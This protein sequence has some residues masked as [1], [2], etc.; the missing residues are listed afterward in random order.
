MSKKRL[1]SWLIKRK[2]DVWIISLLVM[3]STILGAV[4]M[5]GYPQRFEDEG[6]Y[7]SQA[8]AIQKRGTL[9]HY[10]Y[11]YDHPPAGWIQLAGYTSSTNALNRYR[12]AITA[13]REFMLVLHL[14]VIVLLFILA[15]RLGIGSLAAEIGTLFYSLSPLT[16]EFS[17]YVLLDNVALPWFLA[18][19]VLALSPRRHIKTAVGAAICMSIAVLSKE[20]FIVLMPVLLYG[21]W[22]YGDIRNRR[23]MITVFGVVFAMLIGTYVLY[24]AL[25][26]ELFPGVGHVSLLGSMLWQ[27]AGREGSGSI[28]D[29]QSSSRGL[30]AYWLRIDYWM[31]LAGIA[32][33]P[34]AFF[35][36]KLRVAGVGLLIGLILLLR[37]GYL[38]YPYIVAILPFAA[39]IFAG[40]L[41]HV[42]I[43]Q[44]QKK[45][46][47]AAY[48]LL[49]RILSDDL[50]IITA[51]FIAPVWYSKLRI[52]TTVDQDSSSRQAVDWAVENISPRG[53][54]LVVESAIWT[55][56]EDRGFSQP[57]PI[58]LYKTETDQT[59]VKTIGGWRGINY[60]ILNGTTVGAKDFER[61][62]PTLS[63]AINHS[64]I[65]TQFGTDNQRVLIYK[66]QH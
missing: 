33:L 17:R 10:T 44:L 31:M 23:Y 24:A 32:A 19:F 62:F 38:P 60:V 66:V 56:L 13:G 29:A 8:W 27:I 21:L 34:F 53:N 22:Y 51:L 36:R 12:S 49:T 15:R 48:Q 5:T 28:F 39:L 25:K 37:G 9:T 50:A 40:A 3:V 63:E 64:Q 18:A 30:I 26:N 1:H 20:T 59:V 57:D 2:L 42:V 6:T 16:V 65:V 43:T 47:S 55:D 46:D 11:W 54:R 41:H 7:M 61:T 14:I 52:L 58:W 4:N 45:R 35:Y